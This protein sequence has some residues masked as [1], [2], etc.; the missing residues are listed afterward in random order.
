MFLRSRKAQS[1]LMEWANYRL[2]VSLWS[3]V[4]VLLIGLNT[5][6]ASNTVGDLNNDYIVNFADFEILAFYWM[7]TNCAD[8]N[9]CDGA[10][11]EP[12]DGSVDINDLSIFCSHWLDE[13]INPI[14]EVNG[15]FY[16]ISSDDG[17]IWGDLNGND[18]GVGENHT[19]SE[20]H[21]LRIG[22]YADQ[23]LHV[24]Y[25]SIVSFDTTDSLP[26]DCNI[27]S[28]RLELTRGY[29]DY[30]DNPFNWGGNCVIDVANPYFGYRAD[31][32]A[33]DWQAVAD[34]NSIAYFL[35]DPGAEQPMVSTDFNTE[36]LSLINTNGRTQFKFYF[37]NSMNNDA[38]IDCLGFYSG[39]YS[40]PGKRPKLEISYTTTRTPIVE[41]TSIGTEDGRVWADLNDA[42]QAWQ[43]IGAD[44]MA[45]DYL[46]LRLGDYADSYSYRSILS[47]DTSSLPDTCTLM[48]AR[49]QL[50]VGAIG[51]T[52]PFDGWGGSCN[53]DIANPSF[54][55][56]VLEPNDWQAAASGTA[57]ASFPDPNGQTLMVSDDFSAYGLNFIN[58]T[59][60]TQLK[61]YFQTPLNSDPN[62][63]CIYFYSGDNADPNKHPKLIIQYLRN[64]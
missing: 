61:V 31:L 29:E 23:E 5:S 12:N 46:A 37:E 32:D 33:N 34:A 41:Y 26:A 14:I 52:D 6:F 18:R 39:E 16:S 7:D 15:T 30:Q 42:T 9:N 19:S 51:G 43:G 44:S 59:G 53:I 40:D 20:N 58:K 56:S 35:A 2:R 62:S 47:F 25:R 24:G 3:V 22:D 1:S 27:I 50:Y 28:A 49:V 17:R 57:I 8:S 36:G 13:Y 55:A 10:D 60:K 48:S 63:D 4:L 54:G 38:N 64:E 11:F 45:S 21:A